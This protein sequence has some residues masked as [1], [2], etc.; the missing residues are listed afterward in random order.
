VLIVHRFDLD[1]DELT[2]RLLEK[3]RIQ[4]SLV[5]G[6]ITTIASVARGLAA[7]PTV[8]IATGTAASTTLLVVPI[9]VAG[10]EFAH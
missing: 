3:R 4:A 8:A 7:I 9:T 6:A 10:S 2:Q 5:T 1:R